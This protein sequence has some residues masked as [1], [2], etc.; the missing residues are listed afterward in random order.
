MPINYGNQAKDTALLKQPLKIIVYINRDGCEACKL[1][2]L[3]PVYIFTLQ[4]KNLYKLG[5]IIILNTPDIV[6]TET[7]LKQIR[8][9]QTIFYDLDG[10]F[11]RSNPNLPKDE[12]FHTFLLDK[13]NKV[14]L[15]GNPSL[16]IRLKKLYIRTFN[17]LNK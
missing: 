2:A 6:A 15:V 5:V 13:N 16:N 1:Q 8:F 14:I 11:E 3:V 12:R 4:N 9:R 7:T 17:K 10:S